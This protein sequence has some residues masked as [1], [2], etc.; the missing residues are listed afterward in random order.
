VIAASGQSRE[1]RQRRGRGQHSGFSGSFLPCGEWRRRD[2][3]R[4][5]GIGVVKDRETRR[6]GEEDKMGRWKTLESPVLFFFFTISEWPSRKFFFKGD[7]AS[8]FQ[9]KRLYV[10]THIER[11][12]Q[13]AFKAGSNRRAPAI[14]TKVTV[15]CRSSSQD[16]S[17]Q[18]H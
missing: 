15:L 6:G 4:D 10:R 16:F 8:N 11:G 2:E 18:P 13:S 9:P 1:V 17:F 12:Q 7:D 14:F 5:V 3:G